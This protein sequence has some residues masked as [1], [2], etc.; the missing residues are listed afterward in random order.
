VTW[1]CKKLVPVMKKI[2]L[3]RLDII[4][5]AKASYFSSKGWVVALKKPVK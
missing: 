5:L 3:P 1:K 2:V 4:T